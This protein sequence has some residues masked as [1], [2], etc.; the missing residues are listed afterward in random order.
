MSVIYMKR[1]LDDHDKEDAENPVVMS[2]F[3]LLTIALWVTQAYIEVKQ[4]MAHC[5]YFT[6]FWNWIDLLGLAAVLM[7]LVL[8]GL[9]VDWVSVETLRIIAAFGSCFT[10][11]KLID[12]LR[13]FENTAFYVL[14]VQ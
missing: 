4:I 11:T 1:A 8:T 9:R 14:L 2:I 5:D 6:T 13:L 7:V 3:C 10:L 12:W